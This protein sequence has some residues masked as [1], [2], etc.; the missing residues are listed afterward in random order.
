MLAIISKERRTSFRIKYFLAT[1]FYICSMFF[2]DYVSAECRE[3]VNILPRSSYESKAVRNLYIFENDTRKCDEAEFV[4]MS[5]RTPFC[6]SH[7][8]N[9]TFSSVPVLPNG[10]NM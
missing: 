7:D 6:D 3:E 4:L 10:T 9:V 8:L 1:P 2:V 5:S